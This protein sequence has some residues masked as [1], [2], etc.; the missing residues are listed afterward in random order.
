MGLVADV[1]GSLTAILGM[2]LMFIAVLS[3]AV[4]MGYDIDCGCFGPNDPEANAFSGLRTALVRDFIMV[5]QVTYLYF[6]RF[7]N[8]HRPLSI[9]SNQKQEELKK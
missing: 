5:A 2:L 6:W 9:H 4:F 3:H 1:R 7:K 8:H